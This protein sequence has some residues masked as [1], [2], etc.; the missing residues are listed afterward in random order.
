LLAGMEKRIKY[1]RANQDQIF[2]ACGFPEEPG[3][4]EQ[5]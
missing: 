5:P 4:Q 1:L 2:E 3:Q